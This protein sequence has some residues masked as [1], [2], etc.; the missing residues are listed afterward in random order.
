M[1]SRL[2]TASVSSA[3]Q[4][5]S[6]DSSELF[7]LPGQ[8]DAPNQVPSTSLGDRKVPDHTSSDRALTCLIVE[9][10][11]ISQKILETVLTRMGCRCILA[12]DGAEAISIALA[13]ISMYV[14]SAFRMV[15]LYVRQGLTVFSWIC[16]CLWLTVKKQLVISKAPTTR[17]QAR[18]LLLSVLIVDT[19]QVER[20]IYL[21]RL[22]R[23][24]SRK[25]SLSP[26]YGNWDSRRRLTMDLKRQWRL[27]GS[28]VDLH[29]I[30]LFSILRFHHDLFSTFWTSHSHMPWSNSSRFSL[31]NT[32]AFHKRQHCTV[33]LSYTRFHSPMP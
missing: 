23:S 8:N 3:D 1:P 28:P 12:A 14:Y 7:R 19:M 15:H 9:D 18:P 24:P 11:P 2:R 22:L 27:D 4:A 16:T 10:N 31:H 21:L 26:S 32:A 5:S 25:T 20:A 33:D 29:S 6:A 13:D 17:T 30:Y